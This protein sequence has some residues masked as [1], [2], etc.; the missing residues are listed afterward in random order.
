MK[1]F[2]KRHTSVTGD[3]SHTLY[4]PELGEH[5]HSTHGALQESRHVFVTSGFDKASH[6]E[7][8]VNV[9]EV[10]FGTGLN[11]LLTL[12]R[13]AEGNKKV[14]YEALE[15]FPLSESEWTA[16]NLPHLV[17]NGRHASAFARMHQSEAGVLTEISATFSFVRRDCTLQEA[18]LPR[19]C[20]HVVYHDA[21]APQFQPEMWTVDV[22][23]KLFAA[24]LPNGLLT[25]YCAKGSVK[26]ALKAAGFV[27]SHPKGPPGKREMTVAVREVGSKK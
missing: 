25:T 2:S 23:K 16:L 20:Y 4:L 11:A 19:N 21:F 17:R 7:D 22:F 26:R 18:V 1:N 10:G 12:A 24:M 9:L 3:G 5:Y 13:V 6:T 27:L 14:V 8:Q 15:P